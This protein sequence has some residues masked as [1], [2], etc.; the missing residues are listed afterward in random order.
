MTE[1][2]FN[3]R[4]TNRADMTLAEV[5]EK[6]VMDTEQGGVVENVSA[7]ISTLVELLGAIT[8]VLTREQKVEIAKR[9]GYDEQET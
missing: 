4:W 9:L 2:H 7:R 3:T 5:L 8:Y 6:E 1:P